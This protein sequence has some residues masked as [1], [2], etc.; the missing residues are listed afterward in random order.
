MTARTTPASDGIDIS[1]HQGKIDWAKVPAYRL[2][3]TKLTDGVSYP[4][5]KLAVHVGYVEAMR[6]HGFRWLGAYHWLRGNTSAKAQADYFVQV[7]TNRLGGLQHGEL[8]QLDWETTPNI[9]DPTVAQ[10]EEW[11]DRVEQVIGRACVIVYS[12]DWVPGFH[13]WRDRNPTF[14]YWHANYNLGS[15][16]NG[17]QAECVKYDAAV[18]QWTSKA[19]VPGI[20]GGVDMNAVL[21]P[22]V[23]DRLTGRAQTSPGDTPPPP[24][25][26]DDVTADECRAIVAD[27]IRKALAEAT[28][29]GLTSWPDTVRADLEA[30]RQTFNAVTELATLT[31]AVAADV[32]TIKNRP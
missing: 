11:C 13:A 28:G 32:A 31:W 1:H 20:V 8:V 18:W 10:V 12:S 14:P 29:N 30:T 22:A 4:A 21:E 6:A 15:T 2:G 19:S 27:E 23:L 5:D 3:T 16:P 9:A 7:L 25:P 26:G 24:P 17:G